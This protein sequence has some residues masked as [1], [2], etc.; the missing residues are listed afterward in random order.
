MSYW[1]KMYKTAIPRVTTGNLFTLQIAVLH[2]LP[3]L[4]TQLWSDGCVAWGV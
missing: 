4:A 1:Y 3:G 2:V